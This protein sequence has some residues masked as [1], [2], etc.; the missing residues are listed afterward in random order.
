MAWVVSPDLVSSDFR[1]GQEFKIKVYKKFDRV[2]VEIQANFPKLKEPTEWNENTSPFMDF[3]SNVI[4]TEIILAQKLRLIQNEVFGSLQETVES[5]DLTPMIAGRLKE[6]RPTKS[7]HLSFDK[8]V[9]HI[10]THEAITLK[11]L[12]AI[13]WSRNDINIMADKHFGFLALKPAGID[14]KPNGKKRIV[15]GVYVLV[16]DWLNRTGKPDQ[17]R[18]RSR[19]WSL[20]S[21]PDL[22][23]FNNLRVMDQLEGSAL[24]EPDHRSAIKSA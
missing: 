24:I 4:R 7:K 18:V 23:R 8:V 12:E 6:L 16:R 9:H 22:A 5:V 13:G 2:R 21:Y 15:K 14:V 3:A 10:A 17:K 20:E 19:A 1:S 11:D